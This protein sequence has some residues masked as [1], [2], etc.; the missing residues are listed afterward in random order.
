MKRFSL[1]VVLVSLLGISAFAQTAIT[2]RTAQI[3]TNL[4]KAKPSMMGSSQRTQDC[5]T[6]INLCYDDQLVIY[7]TAGGYV[8]GQ[9]EYGD[10]S[11]AD[12]YY[13]PGTTIKGCLI[14]F[15]FA[16]A[17][18][19]VDKFKVRIW[20]ND[21]T[22]YDGSPGAPGTVLAEKLVKYSD[23]VTDVANGDLTY[24]NFGSVTMPADSIFYCGINFGY[25]ANDTIA[26]VTTLDRTGLS[27]EGIVTAV[28]QWDPVAYGADF[29]IDYNTSWGFNGVSHAILPITCVDVCAITVK[30]AAPEVCLNKD[31]QLVASGATTY[32]WA[33]ATGL[34]VTTGDTVI[35]SPSTTTT[36]T[37]TG[38]GGNCTA[39]VTVTIKPKPISKFK[40]GTCSGGIV[41][42]TYTGDVLANP[43]Y[44]W[45]KNG[46]K[47]VG[48]TNNVYNATTSGLYKVRVTNVDNGCKDVS[49]E[50]QVDITCKTGY[51]Q[52]FTAEA[53]PNPFSQSLVINM[54][55]TSS[56]LATVRLVDLSG[57]T[58]HEY[59]KV[60]P[61]APF[62]INENLAPGVYFVRIT[63]GVDEKMI[64]VVK[65]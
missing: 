3:K 41:P 36:Y 44:K 30:P 38:D 48:A 28:E 21:G 16:K 10:V 45:F 12:I 64:K 43:K 63:Q 55:S 59:L 7:S 2:P 24:V 29:W 27:C 11:K 6:F 56:D 32:T 20:D 58:L 52:S 46:V 19:S 23:V 35:A 14:Y 51:V 8:A 57:R 47:I 25:K 53:Y 5:D 65:E 60:D 42:L 50:K 40:I 9:N 4:G 17:A 34:N 15:G 61:S 1:L 13:L 22:F 31:K 33:P 39:T 26:M 54:A 18:N 37:V 49:S 62:E